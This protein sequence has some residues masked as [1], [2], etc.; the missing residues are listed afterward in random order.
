MYLRIKEDV[1]ASG[2][3]VTFPGPRTGNHIR[4]EHW[5]L[6]QQLGRIA[7]ANMS[8]RNIKYEEIPFFWTVQAG[9]TLRYVGFTKD[10]DEIIIDGNIS[11]KKF[12]A[13][14]IKNN[15]IMAAAGLNRDKE[16]DAVHLLMKEQ[17]L[18]EVEALRDNSADIL[19]LV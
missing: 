7:G 15:V 3:I 10:W 4:I 12:I 6:A 8:G 19:S 14:Y 5:R 9:M 17:R 11:H 18:P 13:Y 16:M 1:Y 2:D